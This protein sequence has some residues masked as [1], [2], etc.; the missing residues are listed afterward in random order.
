M[1]DALRFALDCVLF[2]SRFILPFLCVLFVLSCAKR[3]LKKSP[4]IPVAQL[5]V[6]GMPTAFGISCYEA[7]LGRSRMCDIRLN[8]DT[9]SRRHAVITYSPDYGFRIA[10]VGNAEIYVN[11]IEVDG[12]AYLQKGDVIEI[13]GMEMTIEPPVF[14]D[15]SSDSR[16]R[17]EKGAL[18]QLCL[19]TVIQLIVCGELMIHYIADF[20]A[21]ILVAF[22]GLIAVE[23]LYI[24]LNRSSGNNQIELMGMLLTTFG[25]AVAASAVPDSLIKQF[26]AFIIGFAVFVAARLLMKNIEWTM[27]MRY[28]MTVATVLLFAVN[29]LFGKNINGA[30]NWLA[31][32]PMTIQPSELLKFAF[33]FVGASTLDRLLAKR[34]LLLFLAFSGICLGS[35]ALMRDFGTASIYFITMLIIMFMRS[36]DLKIITGV[37][38]ATGAAAIAV[39]NFV[40][41]V[42][43]R[44]AT[45]RHAWEFAADKGYQQTRTMI[46]IASGGIFGVGGGNGNL[47][48]VA[49]SDTDLVFG[50]LC[51]EWGMIAAFSL[52]ACFI[53]FAVYAWRRIPNTNSAF[54]AIAACAAAGLFIFQLS[55]NIFGSTD[56]LPL[57]GVTMPFVSNGGSSMIASWALLSF[58]K[59]VGENSMRPDF[60][61]DAADAYDSLEDDGYDEYDRYS[62]GE[63]RSK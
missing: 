29:L 48:R 19:L 13:G 10:A 17:R 26:A 4:R 57:T 40:P 49:A 18:S 30:K 53:L 8:V 23:W 54:Y 41:Y 42:K 38:A 55:L 9:V 3:L 32:G 21:N 43:R 27:K 63:V 62:Y 20:Q 25:F 37:T 51:E 28:V 15:L 58:I 11:G 22:F 59:A 46:A 24:L 50:F 61:N 33:I 12:F 16:Q 5:C 34:N 44:F 52:A 56:L 14:E 2:A 39:A 31:I 36:G 35:L 45:Y 6:H 1:N 7:T 60:I 47:D